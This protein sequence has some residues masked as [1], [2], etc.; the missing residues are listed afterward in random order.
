MIDAFTS[1]LDELAYAS[2]V[3][4]VLDVSE[5][6]EEI[7]VKYASSL[8]VIREFEVPATKIIYV[9]NKVDLTNAED[10]FDKAGKLGILDTKRVVLVSAEAGYNIGQLKSLI[11][12]MLFE[13]E[14]VKDKEEDKFADRRAKEQEA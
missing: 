1:T 3:L 5:P 7:E 12:L 9:L 8:D 6:V 10:A 13:A 4:L 11:R 14:K 2:L